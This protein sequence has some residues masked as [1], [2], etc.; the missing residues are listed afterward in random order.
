MVQGVEPLT[1][2]QQPLLPLPQEIT[3]VEILHALI[4]GNNLTENRDIVREGAMTDKETEKEEIVKDAFLK[5]ED[6]MK[7]IMTAEIARTYKVK[8]KG[9]EIGAE[10][11]VSPESNTITSKC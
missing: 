3:S 1:E 4:E 2:D 6:D 8:I 5:K 10:V 11:R 9:T 7:I